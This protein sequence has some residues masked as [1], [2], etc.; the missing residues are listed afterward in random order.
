MNSAEKNKKKIS[1][2]TFQDIKQF[3]LDNLKKISSSIILIEIGN[4]FLNIGLA[5]SRNNKLYVKKIFKEILPKDALEKSLPSDPVS[6][7]SF[8]NELR[9]Y[10]SDDVQ[11]I[12]ELH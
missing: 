3:F 12:M 8:L 9:L 11:G 5:K 1:E 6:F 4:D 7:G 10:H 2:Y